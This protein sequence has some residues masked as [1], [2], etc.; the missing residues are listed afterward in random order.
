VDRPDPS[1]AAPARA[2]QENARHAAAHAASSSTLDKLARIGYAVKGGLYAAIGVLA[3]QLAFGEGGET[4]GA[5]GVIQKAAGGTW[6]SILLV[7]IGIG[8]VGYALWRFASAFLDAQ[9][10]GSDSKATAKRVGYFVSGLIHAGL[11]VEAFRLLMGGGAS[12]SEGGA[13]DWTATLLAQPFGPW[14]V[15]LVGLVVIGV[16]GYQLKK[17]WSKDFVRRLRL[18]ALTPSTRDTVVRVGQ[19]GLAARGVVFFILGG[20]LMRAAWTADPD[21]ARGLGGALDA[22]AQAGYGPWL[23]A[24]VAAGLLAYGVYCGVRA[25]RGTFA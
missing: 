4:T 6:G 15:G 10:K 11:A 25:W 23:L 14:L 17:A 8:L 20:F 13:E 1:L 5:G 21:E 24:L 12:A 3:L 2:L 7:V 16:G 18:N 19:F 9:H 22:L